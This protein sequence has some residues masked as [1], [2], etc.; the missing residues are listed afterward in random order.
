MT[1]MNLI[2]PD[3]GI[4]QNP[5]IKRGGGVY[6]HKKLTRNHSL[7]LYHICINPLCNE[8]E[9]EAD[10][11]VNLSERQIANICD[12]LISEGLVVWCDRNGEKN[13]DGL[14]YKATYEG[15]GFL[16]SQTKDKTEPIK[17]YSGNPGIKN[18]FNDD[19]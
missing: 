3:K 4:P 9:I 15:K 11:P 7:V 12:D 13:E 10:V 6:R 19:F 16:S 17:A 18:K 1:I 14:F 8:D 2:D 5:V